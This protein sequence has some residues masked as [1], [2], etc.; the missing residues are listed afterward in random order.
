MKKFTFIL[1]II[2]SIV[3][4]FGST[5]NTWAEGKGKKPGNVKFDI[6]LTFDDKDDLVAV[7]AWDKRTGDIVD[8]RREDAKDQTTNVIRA[9]TLL[10]LEGDD[11]CVVYGGTKYCW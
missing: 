3:I 5:N 9:I 1:L 10:M 2:M 6:L 8:V 11:P 4:F 7:K